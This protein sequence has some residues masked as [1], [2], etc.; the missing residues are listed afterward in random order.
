MPAR[1]N[2]A[3]AALAS[4]YGFKEIDL[5]TIARAKLGFKMDFEQTISAAELRKMK[6]EARAFTAAETPVPESFTWTNTNRTKCP[7]GSVREQSNCASGWAVATAAALSDR[8][9]LQ[10]NG[11]FT[12]PLSHQKL[13]SCT[14][15]N[16][17]CQGGY[18][19]DVFR[20]L[21]QNGTVTGGEYE[22][23][24]GCQMY[25][26]RPCGAFTHSMPCDRTTASTPKCKENKCNNDWYAAKTEKRTYK[27]SSYKWVSAYYND[28]TT[29]Q[30]LYNNGPLVASFWVY[31]DFML[32]KSGIYEHKLGYYPLGLH[33]VKIVGWGVY[34]GTKYWHVAN[35]WGKYWGENGFFRIRRG[36]NECNIDWYTIA[37]IPNNTMSSN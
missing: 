5:Y 8:F 27:I 11:T 18:L 26:I 37:L 14:P 36:T 6:K 3:L 24:E 19:Y 12:T 1:A 2:D 7:I 15:Y 9:C 20:Y 35:S 34:N 10:S 29:K 16:Q 22:S 28:E 4:T 25:E 30:E 32:Y 31:P 23:D 13:V 33:A 17:G 21:Q